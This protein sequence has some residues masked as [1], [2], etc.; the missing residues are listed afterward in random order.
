MKAVLAIIFMLLLSASNVVIYLLR[1]QFRY[2]TVNPE[3]MELPLATVYSF[4]QKDIQQVSTL[5][6]PPPY[7]SEPLPSWKPLLSPL[8]EQVQKKAKL[9]FQELMQK[10]RAEKES[11]AIRL[12]KNY[13]KQKRAREEKAKS[14]LRSFQQQWVTKLKQ[15]VA[16]IEKEYEQ[17][18]YPLQLKLDTLNLPQPK[19][20][21]LLKQLKNLEQEK[22][23]A[24]QK[25]IKDLER[26]REN[27]AAFTT[28]LL[29]L[30][31]QFNRQLLEKKQQK[32][33]RSYKE[34]LIKAWQKQRNEELK[35]LHREVARLWS[36]PNAQ[37]LVSYQIDYS[38][39]AHLNQLKQKEKLWKKRTE[40]YE[41]RL[42]Q[43][44]GRAHQLDVIFSAALYARKDLDVSALYRS[45]WD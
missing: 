32:E 10:W 7:R 41:R 33:N 29:T 21:E 8:K 30:Q 18:K 38:P 23:E 36:F 42:I 22:R 14:Q 9:S 3:Q 34:S 31:D 28:F 35:T 17:R 15:T 13:L 27:R 25:A 44:F 12:Q 19:K 43:N 26:E 37:P 6:V 45:F 11:R 40:G 20:E 2:A 4:I 39:K 16:R 5:Q 24:I 1:H